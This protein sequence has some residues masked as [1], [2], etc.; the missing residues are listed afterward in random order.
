[1]LAGQLERNVPQRHHFEDEQGPAELRA[2]QE[3][4][5]VRALEV[6][7]RTGSE[8]APHAGR[9]FHEAGPPIGPARRV[10]EHRPDLLDGRR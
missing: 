6:P 10:G 5:P 8:G 1:M 7:V 3:A 2:P 9:R 4:R